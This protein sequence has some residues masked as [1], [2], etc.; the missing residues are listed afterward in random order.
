MKLEIQEADFPPG[1]T[2]A[3]NPVHVTFVC[4]SPEDLNFV[5]SKVN[6]TFFGTGRQQTNKLPIMGSGQYEVLNDAMG[7]KLRDFVSKHFT[8]KSINNTE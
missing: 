8:L 5:Y 3:M 1:E 4:E 7:A 2:G 6:T